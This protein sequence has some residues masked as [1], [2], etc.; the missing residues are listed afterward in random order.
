MEIETVR[1]VA[2][3]ARLHLSSSEEEA[4]AQELEE[5]LAYLSLLDEAPPMETHEFNPV[6]IANIMREDEPI[7]NPRALEIRDSMDTYEDLVRGPR[8]S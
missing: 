4:L 6:R 5:V 8:L 1:R 3:I 2:K 7:Q